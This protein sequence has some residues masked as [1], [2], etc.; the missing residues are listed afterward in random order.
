MPMLLS[1]RVGGDE[2]ILAQR[3][4]VPAI[5]PMLDSIGPAMHSNTDEIPSTS[6]IGIAVRTHKFVAGEERATAFTDMQKVADSAMYESKRLAADVFTRSSP[7]RAG[8]ST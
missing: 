1:Q 2:F 4:S 5:G 8:S 3:V 7:L 6:S